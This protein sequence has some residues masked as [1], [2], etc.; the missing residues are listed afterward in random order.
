MLRKHKKYSWLL[1]GVVSLIILS[2]MREGFFLTL[3]SV[4]R[5]LPYNNAHFT[6]LTDYFIRFDHIVLIRLKWFFTFLFSILFI[7][8]TILF[9]YKIFKSLEIIKK[10]TLFY[11]VSILMAVI[12][13]LMGYMSSN[14]D[15]VYGGIRT[16]FGFIQSP[17]L[18]LISLPLFSFL[19]K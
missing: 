10:I 1:I 13:G 3:N 18:L 16:I 11:I 9:N 12:I 17:L 6:F 5:D 14:F 7:G 2:Y 15:N 4:L 8:L 19:K